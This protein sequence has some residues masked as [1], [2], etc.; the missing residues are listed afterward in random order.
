M[1]DFDK[2]RYGWRNDLVVKSGDVIT[3]GINSIAVA[4]YNIVAFNRMPIEDSSYSLLLECISNA[5]ISGTY[6]D[7]RPDFIPLLLDYCIHL[8]SIKDGIVSI[9]KTQANLENF[10]KSAASHSDYL[11]Q[12]RISY[13]D[14]LQKSKYPLKQARILEKEDA[15]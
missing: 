13:L 8:A 6:I 2:F 12:R 9:Q 4:G 11:Q 7:V 14:L 10:I 1:A 15:A 3:K 5:P